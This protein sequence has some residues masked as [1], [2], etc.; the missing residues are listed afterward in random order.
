MRSL[1]WNTVYLQQVF[2]QLEQEGHP[3]SDDDAKHIGP[4]RRSHQG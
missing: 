1:V 3:V 2:Q 4:T